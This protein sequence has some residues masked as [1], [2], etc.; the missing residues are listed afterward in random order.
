VPMI[1][2]NVVMLLILLPLVAALG[3]SACSPE[4]PLAG[5][6]ADTSGA[7]FQTPP[8]WGFPAGSMVATRGSGGLVST[9]DR[10]ASEVG[11]EII[12]RGGNA[13][14]A[15]IATFFALAVVNP[16]AGNLGGGGFLVVR[17]ADGTAAA[18]DFREMAPAAATRD[19]YLDSAGRLTDASTVGHLSSAVPGS[20]AGMWEAHRRFGSLAWAELL[21]PAINLATGIVVHE[22]LAA[23][24][25]TYEGR[26]SRNPASAAALLPGGRPPRVG[27]RLEQ[28]D[29][30][31]TLR[32][33]AAEGKAGFYA[34]RTAELL[35]AEM[36]RGGGIV[37]RADL[38]AYEAV[39]RDPII[40]EYRGHQVIAMSQPSSGGAT[41]AQI[42]NILEGYDLRSMG[43]M[44]ADHMH[45][46]A[47]A[48]KLA[49]ADRNAYLADPDFVPQ[50]TERMIS[51]AYAA[52][53]RAGIRMD[54]ATPAAEIR[55]GLGP[56]PGAIAL[57]RLEPE[58][59]THFSIVDAAGNA[60][61]VTTTLNSLYGNAITV[62]GAGFL[63]NNVMDD[64]AAQPGTANQFGLVQ[65]EANAI[66]PGKRML[67]AMTPTVV[68]DPDGRLRLVVGTPGGATIITTVA[69]VISNVVDF[70]M[71]VAAATLAPRAHH[72]HLPDILRYERDGMLPEV[73]RELRARGH[74]VEERPGYSGD[75][76]AIAVHAD[77]SASGLSDP[78]RGGAAL[79]VT[80]VRQVVQ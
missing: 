61:A 28:R 57:T 20:V 69:Q 73:E 51:E 30:A 75:V 11:V 4:P 29:L 13:V 43:H 12:R 40:F 35:E 49:Y 48:V 26:L 39:W 64:F 47:E 80:E 76:Q 53:R 60:A 46:W 17:L 18:L 22:R 62:T 63:L 52:E 54:R 65:G 74:V 66:E 15:A 3:G 79:T 7:A 5:S 59:T 56:V 67:S 50:P 78:R 27:D 38:A 37:T 34:G 32:R 1:H 19:M 77:G 14:D 23:S 45:V 9:T 24:L 36:R 68:V 70:G 42:L 33:I 71:D 55:P 72:Q 31:E 41:L 2:A 8:E 16:E 25:R 21:E 6:P 44:S 10:V 58:H